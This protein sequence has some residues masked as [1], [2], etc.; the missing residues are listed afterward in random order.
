VGRDIFEQQVLFSAVPVEQI[1]KLQD[2]FEDKRL[3]EE[4]KKIMERR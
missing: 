4:I 3:L 1:Y 2:K